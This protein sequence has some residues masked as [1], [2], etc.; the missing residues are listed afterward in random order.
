MRKLLRFTHVLLGKWI[1]CYELEREAW[2]RV[3][4]DAKYGSSWGGWCSSELVRGWGGY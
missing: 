2:L 4:V 3:E 1:W